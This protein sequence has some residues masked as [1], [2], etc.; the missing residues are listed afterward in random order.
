MLK[1]LWEDKNIEYKDYVGAPQGPIQYL[2]SN[3]ML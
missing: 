1:L 3:D 2:H